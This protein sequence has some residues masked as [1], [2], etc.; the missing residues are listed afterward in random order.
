MVQSQLICHP[1]PT[2]GYRIWEGDVSFAYMSD[3]EPALGAR[4]FPGDSEWLSGFAL[5]RD[6]TLLLHDAQYFDSEYEERIGWGHSTL[7]QTLA[8]S[9]AAAPGRLVTFHHDPSH[10]D[11]E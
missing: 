5:A 10:A 11:R 7:D 2:V 6:A 8:Y 1:G 4:E 9:H 3:H